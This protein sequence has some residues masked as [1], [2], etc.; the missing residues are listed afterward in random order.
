MQSLHCNAHNEIICISTEYLRLV[1]VLVKM[2]MID[3][4]HLLEHTFEV[5]DTAT[6]SIDV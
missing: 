4:L 1:N 3:N 2:I 6:I 5:D